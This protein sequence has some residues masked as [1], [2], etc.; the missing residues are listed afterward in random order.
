MFCKNCGKQL[1]DNSLVCSECGTQQTETTNSFSSFD[2][3]NSFSQ[4][5]TVKTPK[6]KFLA[7]AFLI[8]AAVVVLAAVVLVANR[9][10][11]SNTF[12]KLTSSPDKYF[13]T[14][15][16]SNVD[17][18]VDTI[19]ESISIYSNVAKKGVSSES[20]ITFEVDKK[21]YNILDDFTE[22]EFEIA[23]NLDWFKD[24]S[25]SLNTNAKDS[26]IDLDLG[27]K[28]NG[29]NFGSANLIFDPQD[30]MMYIGLPDYNSDYLATELYGTSEMNQEAFMKILEKLPKEA[31]F[32][33]LLTKY[34][35]FVANSVED[36]EETKTEIEAEGITQKVT[37]LTVDLDGKLAINIS[38]NLLKEVKKDK[39]L[40]KIIKDIAKAGDFDYDEDDFLDSLDELI[41]EAEDI[42]TDELDDEFTGKLSLYVNNKGEIVGIEIKDD[43][44]KFTYYAPQKGSKFGFSMQ[45]KDETATYFK[46]TGTG[47]VSGSKRSGEFDISV[48][49]LK[50]LNVKLDKVNMDLL[51]DG[52]FNGK[53]TLSL[54]DDTVDLIDSNM[55]YSSYDFSQLSDFSLTI[56]SKT[57]SYYKE[58]SEI[59]LNYKDKPYVELKIDSNTGK[60]K[61]V[62]TPNNYVSTEDYDEVEEWR[63]NFDRDKF[64]KKLKKA[65]FHDEIVEA[66]QDAF[67]NMY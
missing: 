59:T 38:V 67:D 64:V 11:I 19:A 17:D 28:I 56:S 60:G 32:K 51:N 53:I 46:I 23:E 61:N 29:E 54:P 48:Q 27:L 25:L 33:K 57:K 37:E 7:P 40:Q 6:K 10:V 2:P 43:Y 44:S 42:D 14:V 30:E 45:F 15:V 49:G 58:N 36:V 65:D 66:V 47:K 35:K 52:V 55:G 34:I 26:K 21:F 31:K 22:D 18:Y 24:A 16:E 39:D 13:A 1:D 8:P 4:T 63:E 3:S 5:P 41:E 20:D 62:K 9:N 50:V 12:K